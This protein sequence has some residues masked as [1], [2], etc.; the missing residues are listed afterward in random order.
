M[1]E[2]DIVKKGQVN[3]K[4]LELKREFETGNN[5]KEYKIKAIISSIVYGKEANNQILG[6]YYLI[7]WKSYSK[8]ENI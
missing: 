8:E 7:L 4:L 5:N 2:Q 3:K 6:L 1:L